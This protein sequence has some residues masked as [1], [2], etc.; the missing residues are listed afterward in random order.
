MPLLLL[1]THLLR[2]HFIPPSLYRKVVAYLQNDCPGEYH[3]I[4]RIVN[5]YSLT[6]Q[7]NPSCV[8]QKG[9]SA[10]YYETHE[11]PTLQSDRDVIVRVVA[12]GLCG[13]D[14]CIPF[15]TN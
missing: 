9:G 2:T 1:T 5:W 14:V 6:L 15:S 4:D 11:I 12:T 3:G 10:F 13:S 8:L 7:A